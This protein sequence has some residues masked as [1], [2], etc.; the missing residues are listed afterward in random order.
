MPLMSN[1]RLHEARLTF[2]MV[3]PA[4]IDSRGPEPYQ[5]TEEE[6]AKMR[7][8]TPD[9]RAAVGKTILREC[10]HRWT[11]V[12]RIVG[13]LLQD[14]ERDYPNL[15]GVFLLAVMEKLEEQGKIEIAGDV[16]SM[17]HSEIRLSRS[18]EAGHEA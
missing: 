7:A 9:E 10:S 2:T 12:A 6:I 14:F 15:P 8:S 18:S 1:V 4:N 16:W 5:P 3:G 13:S 11:K 17:R